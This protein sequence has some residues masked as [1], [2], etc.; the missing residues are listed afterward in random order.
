[1]QPDA[2]GNR[3]CDDHSLD[4]MYTWESPS[5]GVSVKSCQV[6]CRS[7]WPMTDLSLCLLRVL[8]RS[9]SF[10]DA[11]LVSHRQVL[12]QGPQGLHDATMCIWHGTLVSYG[13][14]LW[15][16]LKYWKG[17]CHCEIFHGLSF[18]PCAENSQQGQTQSLKPDNQTLKTVCVRPARILSN[19]HSKYH[20]LCFP[21]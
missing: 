14:S 21:G 10:T 5:P 3:V 9:Q 19:L 2:S 4:A 7:S 13:T 12:R 16:I 8:Q 11:L 6:K 18:A 17:S 1:M 20:A 15:N